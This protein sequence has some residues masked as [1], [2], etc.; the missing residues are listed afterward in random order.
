MILASK[1]MPSS[2]FFIA[3]LKRNFPGELESA[4][5]LGIYF[6]GKMY[7]QKKKRD[8]LGLTTITNTNKNEENDLLVGRLN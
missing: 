7:K 8:V 2:R 3:L 4:A 6:N 1:K 5:L